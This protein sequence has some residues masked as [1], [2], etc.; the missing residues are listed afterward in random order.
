VSETPIDFSE[1]DLSDLEELGVMPGQD[2]TFHPILEVWREVLK[3]ARDEL[4]AK[5]TPQWANRIVGSYAEMRYADMVQFQRRYYGKIIELLDVLDEEI[6]SDED[7]L[8]Y[9]DPE[10]DAKENAHHYKNLL[11][12]WQLAILQ[13]ELDWDTADALASVEIAAISEVHKMFFGQTGITAFLE[14]IGFEF[15]EDDQQ[16]LGE[17]LAEFKVA[18]RE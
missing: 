4:D 13:W 9:S 3:P 16:A 6:A 1:Q 12:Q 15:T 8:T 17:A 11:L 10:E 18:S 2:A 5:V 7:C 14:N